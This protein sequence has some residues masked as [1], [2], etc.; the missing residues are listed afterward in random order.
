V[1]SPLLPAR[2]R[3][4]AEATAPNTTGDFVQQRGANGAGAPAAA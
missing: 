2:A 1:V 3:P 4:A